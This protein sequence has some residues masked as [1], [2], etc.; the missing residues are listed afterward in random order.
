M[1]ALE[2]TDAAPCPAHGDAEGVVPYARALPEGF[3]FW[4]EPCLLF[5]KGTQSEWDHYAPTRAYRLQKGD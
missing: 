3:R 2:H 1:T 5:F 4:C